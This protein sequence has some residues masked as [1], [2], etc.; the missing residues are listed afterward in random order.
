MD[1]LDK[2]PKLKEI[3]DN[4]RHLREPDF[5]TSENR[6][7]ILGILDG[8][9]LR[10]NGKASDD[11]VSNELTML[12]EALKQKANQNSINEVIKQG[13]I[14][15][16]A[17][18]LKPSAYFDL[19]FD[20][21]ENLF[22]EKGNLN[23]KELDYLENLKEYQKSTEQK[24]IEKKKAEEEKRKE[25]EQIV[26]EL[27]DDIA[28]ILRNF[29]IK[30]GPTPVGTE[31]IKLV[32]ILKLKKLD[33]ESLPIWHVLN[34]LKQETDFEKFVKKMNS[35]KQQ[36]IDEMIMSFLEIYGEEYRSYLHQLERLV[37][38][39]GFATSN[40]DQQIFEVKEHLELE[41]FQNGLIVGENTFT[42]EDCDHMSG[43]QF[44]KLLALLFK[45]MGYTVQLT[46]GSGDQGADLIIEK[47]GE[48]QVVQCK[49]SHGK[50]SNK[51]VQ[52][53]GTAIKHYGADGGMVITN[54][55]F[56]ES[57]KDL[58][59]SNGIKLIDRTKLTEL[60]KKHQVEKNR[61]DNDL[62]NSVDEV[63]ETGLPLLADELFLK[64]FQELE[65]SARKPVERRLLIKHLIKTK[66]F[67]EN[68]A[69]S[70][71]WDMVSTK[72]IY[73]SDSDHYNTTT[74]EIRKKILDEEKRRFM[75]PYLFTNT[76]KGLEGQQKTP[77]EEKLFIKELVK[78]GN[79]TEDEA[80]NQIRKKLRE[81]SIYESKPG[82]YNTV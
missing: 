79:F 51:A 44:E 73:E 13:K 28:L 76:L 15:F 54:N 64:I 29:V 2:Y 27:D 21:K 8:I 67:T 3:L 38:E 68:S 32:K 74:E 66:K 82:Y 26:S 46:K 52:E 16:D 19:P 56:Q 34:Y 81:A 23:D 14:L 4:W 50:I 59:K 69:S 39:K 40:L 61:T 31:Y 53:I 17:R 49:N 70:M 22:L 36:K 11:L 18:L 10:K 30:Y 1:I 5:I 63:D 42:V 7:Y 77:V 20:E 60:L 47:W 35:D 41:R 55:L 78:T 58:A 75:I 37:R 33:V 12:L 45:K 6:E 24:Q 9:A 43:L 71:I 62:Q 80:R 72:K 25:V 57:A 65:G 48:R